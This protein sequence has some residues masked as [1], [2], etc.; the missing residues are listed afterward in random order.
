MVNEFKCAKERVTTKAGFKAEGEKCLDHLPVIRGDGELAYM[1]PLTRLLVPRSAVSV[2]NCSQN[3]PLT[4]EDIKGRMI[5]ANPGAV[6]V[7]VELSEYHSP[8]Y[9]GHN[10]TE[11]FE[12]KS[13]LYTPE[14][15]HDYEQMLL[16]PSNERAV[17]KQF[18]S[19]YYQASGQCSPSR[20]AQD[21]KWGTLVNPQEMLTSWWDNAK[22][23]AYWWGS[24]WGV[25]DSV[26]TLVN[27]LVG[28]RAALR[29]QGGTR[30]TS[31]GVLARILLAP[32]YLLNKVYQTA[33]NPRAGAGDPAP[34]YQVAETEMWDWEAERRD[35]GGSAK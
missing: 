19:Y 32:S 27:Y 31:T 5:A 8:D 25:W 33:A 12:V 2:L 14:E 6:K 1:A 15:I 3:F 18:S 28:V 35:L 11:L 13:L 17:A 16:G 4:F 29:V 23:W 10:H 22:E 9:H 24:V 20:D 21:F 34:T 26:V 7:N 30:P